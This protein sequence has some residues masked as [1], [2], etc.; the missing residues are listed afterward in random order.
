M[1]ILNIKIRGRRIDMFHTMILMIVA[2]IILLIV[3]TVMFVKVLGQGSKRYDIFEIEGNEMVVLAGIPVRYRLNDIE[4]VT[5]S[6]DMGSYGSFVGVMNIKKK[7]AMFGRRFLFDAST[8]YK[9]F[10]LTSTREE[11]DLATD[12]L[13]EKLKGHG[14]AYK[15]IEYVTDE[16]IKELIDQVNQMDDE[17][18]EE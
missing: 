3:S 8:Y 15:K 14:I 2:S 9:K 12:L 13:I 16:E 5:F 11:I 7:D 1:W 4:I 18:D 17:L 10:V 6:N